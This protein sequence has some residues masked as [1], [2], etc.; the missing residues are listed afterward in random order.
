MACTKVSTQKIQGLYAIT[1][2]KKVDIALIEDAITKH[3]VTILQYRHKTENE[4]LKYH[5]A[6]QLRE[7]C[8]THN[9][10]FI[11]NDDINLCQK[12]GAD[13]V[14]LGKSDSSVHIARTQLGANSIIGVSCYNQLDLAIKAQSEGASYVA[15]GALFASSTKPNS[16]HCPLSVIEQAKSKL[17]LPIVGIGGITFDNQHLA[18]DAG[19][20]AVA[21]VKGMFEYC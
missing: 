18:L 4:Q 14:H 8:S 2:N 13:G 16:K 20:D 19:C 11:V 6:V 21:M 12:V 17:S 15:F 3:K 10:L 1:P 7:L 5:E 9:T